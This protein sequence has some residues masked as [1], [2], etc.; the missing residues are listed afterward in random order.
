MH[1]VS[2]NLYDLENSIAMRDG[3][4]PSLV[5]FVK[6]AAVLKTDKAGMR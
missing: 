5:F 4:K 2:Q 3:I 1:N 6:Y